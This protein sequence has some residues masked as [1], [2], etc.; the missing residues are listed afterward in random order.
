MLNDIKTLLNLLDAKTRLRVPLSIILSLII[1]AA[2]AVG[3]GVIMPFLLILSDPEAISKN[4]M[5]EEVFRLVGVESSEIFLLMLGFTMAAMFLVKNAL[6]IFAGWWQIRFLAEGEAELSIRLVARYNRLPYLDIA[7][8]NSAELIRNALNV[9]TT[10]VSTFL[11]SLLSLATELAVLV[12]IGTVIFIANQYIAVGVILF[13]FLAAMALYIPMHRRLGELGQSNLNRQSDVLRTLKEGLGAAKEIRVLNREQFFINSFKESREDL[14]RIR[15][16]QGFLTS[17]G[18]PYLEIIMLLGVMGVAGLVLHSEG[19]AEI[20]SALGLLGVAGLR[21]MPSVNRVLVL[22]QSI[23]AA[24]PAIG[25]LMAEFD[26]SCEAA[27]ARPANAATNV[28][29]IHLQNVHFAYPDRSENALNGMDMDIPWGS[30]VGLVGVSGSGK[31]TLVN[32]MLGLFIPQSGGM[33][34]DGLDIHEDLGAWRSRVG[35]V[36]QTIYLTDGS[37]RDNIALGVPHQLVDD[38]RIAHA[39]RMAHLGE[40]IEGLPQGINTMIGED[41]VRLSG[42]QRQRVGIARALYH[43]P[44]VLIFDEATSSLDNETERQISK[45]MKD[46]GGTKTII[47]IAHRL[48]T[49]RDCDNVVLIQQGCKQA[50]GTFESLKETSAE[51]ASLL[52]KGAH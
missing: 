30:S 2:E 6:M 39:I 8:R 3:I 19:K 18:R 16:S 43:D 51:F 24:M 33:F 10:A 46:L 21:V 50:E 23:R 34:V 27:P 29:G 44:D 9:I 31:S 13:F 22:A 15:A 20:I 11:L 17:L 12:G 41:G 48:S 32:V 26:N 40:V 36:P 49:I 52:N 47:I 38:D 7:G 14:A 5:L 28:H 25:M 42:G 1:S 45:M 4:T 35:Y 37:L